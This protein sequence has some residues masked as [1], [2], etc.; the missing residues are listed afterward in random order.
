MFLKVVEARKAQHS[1]SAP[2]QAT[3]TILHC[4]VPALFCRLFVIIHA[5]FGTVLFRL[6]AG[7]YRPAWT[8]S[9]GVPVISLLLH[10]HHPMQPA[11]ARSMECPCVSRGSVVSPS[12]AQAMG[13]TLNHLIECSY[14]RHDFNYLVAEV[15]CQGLRG[16]LTCMSMGGG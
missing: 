10:V 16:V 13:L 9:R 8:R 3:E 1:T 15:R 2:R 5:L 14:Q 12:D 6:L 7:G 4:T 11:H